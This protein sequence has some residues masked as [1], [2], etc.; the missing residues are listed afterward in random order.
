MAEKYSFFIFFFCKTIFIVTRKEGE[1]KKWRRSNT[2]NFFQTTLFGHIKKTKSLHPLS[3]ACGHFSWSTFGLH[4]VMGPTTSRIHAFFRN[5]PMEMLTWNGTM[6]KMP[7][8]MGQLHGP[9][10]KHPLTWAYLHSTCTPLVYSIISTSLLSLL[11][12]YAE[13][14]GNG[15]PQHKYHSLLSRFPSI[16]HE[17]RHSNEPLKNSIHKLARIMMSS[18]WLILF[19]ATLTLWHSIMSH[20][21]WILFYHAPML[22]LRDSLNSTA[23]WLPQAWYNGVYIVQSATKGDYTEYDM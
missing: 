19:I 12:L 18:L 1:K 13:T 8:D 14:L 22:T 11:L 16:Y 10:C 6:E 9:W 15:C 21:T 23:L 3:G 20:A 4:L 17:F 2:K 5:R 7:F